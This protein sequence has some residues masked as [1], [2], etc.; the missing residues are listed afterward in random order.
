MEREES[1]RLTFLNFCG[2]QVLAAWVLL[3]GEEV[4]LRVD[5]NLPMTCGVI[6]SWTWV[7]LSH[8]TDMWGSFL[9]G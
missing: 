5:L 3:G 8:R 2:G 9:A 6:F 7:K 4:G 1:E